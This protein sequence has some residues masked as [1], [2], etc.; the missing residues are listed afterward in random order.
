MKSLLLAILLLP[1]AA[2][3]ASKPNVLFLFADDMRAD[4]IAALGNPVV[5]TPNL[6]S[7]VQRG[8]AFRNAF[9]FGG[10]SPAVCTPSRNMLLSGNAFYRWKDYQPPAGN[11]GKNPNK[12]NKGGGAKGMLAPGDA[13]RQERQ[14]RA[15][16]PGEVPD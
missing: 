16:D 8:F 4:S 12:K 6:D 14:H 10:N 3:A 2:S 5:K 9:C 13:P 1:M 7:I 11:P 15:P